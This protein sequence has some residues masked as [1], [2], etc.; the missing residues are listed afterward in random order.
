MF[1][2]SRDKKEIADAYQAKQMLKHQDMQLESR[3]MKCVRQDSKYFLL[4]CQKVRT[5]EL[6]TEL[7]ILPIHPE[8]Y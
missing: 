6:I 4:N 3:F 5:K 8:N 7:R 1:P 2:S